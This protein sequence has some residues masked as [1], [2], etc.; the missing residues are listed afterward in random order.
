MAHHK[1]A[2]KRIRQTAKRTARNRFYRTRIKNISKAV[3][4]A[5]AAGDKEKALEALKVA[6]KEFHKYVSKGVLKKNTAARKV[7][8]LHKLVNSMTEAA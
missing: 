1:S 2:L 7:S 8:R 6:N 3:R 4:E 5:V